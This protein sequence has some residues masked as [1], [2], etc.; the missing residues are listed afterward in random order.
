MKRIISLLAVL[1]LVGAT[2]AIGQINYSG[3]TYSENFDT[4]LNTDGNG[5][6]MSGV[7]SVGA[8][9]AIPTLTT[10]RAARVGGTGTGTFALFAD[11]GGSGTGRLYSYGTTAGSP[12]YYERALGSVGS[13][14][15]IP[16]FGTYFINASA[17]TYASLTFNFDREV[18]RNQSA[19]ADQSL[20]FSYGLLSGGGGIT[21]DNFLTSAGMTA[22]PA[23]NATSPAALGGVASAGRDGNAE[24]YKAHVSATITGISWAPGDTLFI[25]WSDADD[26]G[27]DA[28]ISIDNLTL[29][30]VVPEPSCGLLL[31]LGVAALALLRRN[32]R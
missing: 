22:Y 23:L 1:T 24:P 32:S 11:W 15:T 2:V 3:G 13:G 20:T 5:T 31:G 9:D 26:T 17:E 30:A 4:I 10:W 25:R 14:T 29:V 16:G 21:A 6:T 12:I 18:W 8:Q 27:T 19:A 7:G 28:G